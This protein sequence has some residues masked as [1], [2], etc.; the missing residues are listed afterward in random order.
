[1]FIPALVDLF[2]YKVVGSIF[3]LACWSPIDEVKFVKEFSRLGM[4]VT[5]ACDPKILDKALDIHFQGVLYIEQN[6]SNLLDKVNRKHFSHWYKWLIISK[7]IPDALHAVRYDSDMAILREEIE[8]SDN[9]TLSEKNVATSLTVDPATTIFFDDI[10]VHPEAGAT[11]HNWAYWSP[12]GLQVTRDW[13]RI[14][15]RMDVQRYL[16]RIAAPVAH[17][18][19]DTYK[20][21][22][23]E[24]LEDMTVLDSG[25]RCGF[26]ATLLLIEAVNA[27]GVLMPVRYW[28]SEEK[29]S[30][31]AVLSTEE[32][33]L[34][35]GPLR[36]LKRRM[37]FVDFI[38]PM[39]FI[40]VGFTYLAERESSSNMYVEP[41]TAGVW[42]SCLAIGI[43]LAI[44]QRMA[45]RKREDKDG[46]FIA[47]L[48]TWLQQDASAVS[49]GLSG[50]WTFIVLSVCSMLVHAYYTS[51][52]VSALMSTG[53]G[54]PKTLRELADSRYAIASEDH[55]FIRDAMFNV[56]TNWDE[57]EYLKKRK[58]TSKFYQDIHYGVQLV[59]QGYTAYHAEY[60]QLY[61][62]LYKFSDIDI[63]KMQHVDTI[64]E[65]MTWLTTTVRGQWTNIFKS[66]GAWLYETGLA[67][68][69]VSQ[70]QIKLPP[71]RAALLAERVT[72]W[73]V[74]PLLALTTLGA[75]ASLGLLGLEIIF[76]KWAK[77]DSRVLQMSN[78]EVSL[79]V[80]E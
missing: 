21:S 13:Q 3:V 19:E 37:E 69:L 52:I 55:D 14:R 4:S 22:F 15:R 47:V 30:T 28:V 79:I 62:Y 24:Y 57:L 38:V 10:F 25:L 61:H 20:G 53:R 48:A 44:A 72:F 67:R 9:E 70:L 34:G 46:A 75:I 76:A 73:D 11:Q 29:N 17:Y 49:D 8:V 5:F 26:G 35:G 54:G 77:K 32:A 1:M 40:S 71:C 74:A 42:W 36:I 18:S 7:E 16:F 43:T 31:Q 41:F 63:C 27:T 33:E 50:R 56:Q 64:P 80:I 39:W 59:R 78:S 2:K 60:H 66:A 45:S 58:M 68:R 12:R 23:A 51:A 65:A 6:N